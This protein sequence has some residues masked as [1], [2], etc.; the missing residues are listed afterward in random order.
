M[1]YS[2]NMPAVS[3]LFHLQMH[4][5]NGIVVKS[6]LKTKSTTGHQKVAIRKWLSFFNQWII[7]GGQI[8][9]F[10]NVFTDQGNMITQNVVECFLIIH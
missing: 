4:K 5:P 8:A 7:C 3:I 9:N 1:I 6:H 10:F 2:Q